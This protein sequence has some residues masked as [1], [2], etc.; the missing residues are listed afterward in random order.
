MNRPFANLYIGLMSGTSLDGI[1]AALMD[2]SQHAETISTY[3]QP[4]SKQLNQQ[5]SRLTQASDNEIERMAKAEQLLAMEYAS[6]VKTLLIQAQICADKITAIGAHGQTIRHLANASNTDG[7]SIQLLD[8][9]KLAVETGIDVVS[10]FRRKDIALGGQGAPLVPAFHQFIF[11]SRDQSRVVINL[12][13]IANLTFLPKQKTCLGYD[14]GP[15]NT[16]IDHWYRLHNKGQYDNHGEWA[17]TG[18]PH[19]QLLQKLLD[20]PYFKKSFPKSTGPEYFNLEW[21]QKYLT[22]FIAFRAEDVQATLIELSA[23][24]IGVAV[25]SLDCCGE[26]EV[27]FCGGG[28]HNYF[29]IERINSFLKQTTHTTKRLC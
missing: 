14:I 26:I 12:G 23:Y 20:D 9:A 7:F 10:D 1:D 8:P 17:R 6:A 2:F 19:Q 5:L 4:F 3:Y 24:S 25:K 21:L 11:S 16:L 15:A 18:K 27:F 29:L 13:G 28:C 22:D